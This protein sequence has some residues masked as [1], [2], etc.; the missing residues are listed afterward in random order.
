MDY[1]TIW[2]DFDSQRLPV[3]ID[4][5]KCCANQYLTELEGCVVC[6]DCGIVKQMGVISDDQEFCEFAEASHTKTSLFYPKSSG[7]TIISGN[8]NMSR[9]NNWNSMPYDEKVLFQVSND[10]KAKM[11]NYF[12]PKL[13]EDSIA[14][15]KLLDNK[16]GDDGKKEIHRG[17]IRDGL[18]AA[19]VYFACKSNYVN[20]T[21]EE[22]SMIMNVELSSFNTCTKLYTKIMGQE[23]Q[24]VRAVDF[25]DTY[26]NCISHLEISFKI[27][28][29]IKKIC[30]AVEDLG[31]LDGSIPQN[32]TAGCLYFTSTEMKLDIPQKLLSD[33]F[34]ISI[35]TLCKIHQI[36]GYHKSHIYK[37]IMDKKN[38]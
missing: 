35:N 33:R 37:F 26:C 30:E 4:T 20:K 23:Q 18:I 21:P 11:R 2:N 13:I 25:V 10:M 27:Q 12:Q 1:D 5:E 24:V 19:C 8:S 29:T 9:I 15:F 22:I 36:I 32:I 7:S 34:A 17:R 3:R 31:I 16:K 28:N 38:S 6:I 14:N